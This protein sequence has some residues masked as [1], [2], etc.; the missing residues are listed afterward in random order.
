MRKLS[1]D[2]PYNKKCKAWLED[3]FKAPLVVLTPSCTA[4][5]EMG[6]LLMNLKPGDEVIVPSY[7]FS[8]TAS[9]VALFGGVPVFIDSCPKTLNLD[10]SQIENLI[11]SKTKGVI[12]M[13]Y[14]GIGCDMDQILALCKKYNLFI[15]EDA[16]QC[17]GAE[18]NYK[19]LGTY[20]QLGAFSFHDTKN[21]SCGE[22]GCLVVNDPELVQRAEI[23]RDKGTNR[24]AF[25]RG[26][27]DKYTWI[28]IG[29]SYL[30][31]DLQA[32]YLLN[33][34]MHLTEITQNRL[35]TWH[36]YHRSLVD[37]EQQGFLAR[38]NCPENADHN[39]HIYYIL[40]TNSEI[41]KDLQI[42]LN[43]KDIPVVSHYMPLHT[44]PAGKTYGRT[45][46]SLPIAS[47]FPYR[48]LRLPIDYKMSMDDKNR[49]IKEIKGFFA[50][51]F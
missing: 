38:M 29:S 25:F 12:P 26:A 33:Q 7:T 6:L 1:G 16:A 32:E 3:Y 49:V 22:G 19:K 9:A 10:A 5:L 39:A 17:M 23:I 15:L 27:V 14:A 51:F 28:D 11:T 35:E 42:Y 37:L 47:D 46:G 21:I 4:A 30:M 36:F 41:C 2:G 34:L 40:L 43:S 18:L 31:S 20:G 50:K 48:L 44:S 45:H 13:H 24:S 8:S